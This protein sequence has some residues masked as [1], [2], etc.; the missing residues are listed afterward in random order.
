MVESLAGFAAGVAPF[1]DVEP[2]WAGELFGFPDCLELINLDLRDLG[3]YRYSC[4]EFPPHCLLLP[5]ESGGGPASFYFSTFANFFM[6]SFGS[7]LWA[8]DNAAIALEV[9]RHCPLSILPSCFSLNPGMSPGLSPAI[10]RTFC[11]ALP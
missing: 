4:N 6:Y 7:S 5:N 9:N 1:G 10:S 8:F 3:L 2:G 11:N